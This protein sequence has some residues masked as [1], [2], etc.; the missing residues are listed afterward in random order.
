MKR[1][2][3]GAISTFEPS[4]EREQPAR[5]FVK[6]PPQLKSNPAGLDWMWLL[7]SQRRFLA[8]WTLSGVVLVTLI[9]FVIP[10]QYR[11]TT[12]LMPPD[13]QGGSR[14]AMLAAAAGKLDAGLSSLAGDFLGG[15][16][17]GDLFIAILRSRT[18]QDRL[19]QRFDLL[20]VYRARYLE[21]ARKRL[22]S[23]TE[24]TEDRKSGVIS[25]R[26]AALRIALYS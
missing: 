20:R 12:E 13:S 5:T 24:V 2:E 21:D 16:S 11:S 10:K 22:T 17:S 19:I 3:Q 14:L 7:W 6:D 23:S 1:I 8:R 26:A 4:V 9:A 25:I 15:K 18:V